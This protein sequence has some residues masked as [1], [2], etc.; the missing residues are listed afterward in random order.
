M[1]GIE[2]PRS[3][4]RTFFRVSL[5]LLL[6]AVRFGAPCLDQQSVPHRRR[7][8]SHRLMR[9]EDGLEHD[10]VEALLLDLA[11]C[12]KLDHHCRRAA[13]SPVLLCSAGSSSEL[14]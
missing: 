2:C 8:V 7:Q 12:S 5:R 9:L 11:V 13:G 3:S 1:V 10:F 6:H 4:C 14:P